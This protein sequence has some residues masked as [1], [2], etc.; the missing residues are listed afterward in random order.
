MVQGLGSHKGLAC[1]LKWG[2]PKIGGT[3]LGLPITK[4]CSNLGSTLRSP[5][6][7]KPPGIGFRFGRQSGF[8]TCSFGC[9][10][11]ILQDACC[12]T[13]LPQN[14]THVSYS[15]NSLKEAI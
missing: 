4:D 2:F 11:Q 6:L 10:C 3:S 8:R 15:L 7:G 9:G 13:G 1:G 14:P 12:K 5:G